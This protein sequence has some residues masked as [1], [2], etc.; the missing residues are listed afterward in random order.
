MENAELV[1][2]MNAER[3]LLKRFGPH[4]SFT[5]EDIN[6]IH[7]LFLGAIYEWAGTYRSV[8]LSKGGFPFA[9]AM[10]IPSVMRNFEHNVLR[11]NTPC[12]GSTLDEIALKIAIV[13]VE[14]LIIQ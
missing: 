8:N 10:A 4:R 2:Y 7:R 1:G 14:L 11:A 9:T 5:A 6:I 12:T 3:E 13:H